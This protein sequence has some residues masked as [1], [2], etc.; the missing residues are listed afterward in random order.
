MPEQEERTTPTQVKQEVCTIR[1]IFPVKS[2][3]DAI[4]IKK[5]IAEAVSDKPDTVTQ[6]SISNMPAVPSMR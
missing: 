3:E 4:A 1:V 2:D 6:F 5:K